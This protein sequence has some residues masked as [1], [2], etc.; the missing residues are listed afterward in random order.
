MASIKNLLFDMGAVL[1]NIDYNKTAR[2]FEELGVENFSKEFSQTTASP[3]FEE[4]EMGRISESAFYESIRK[5]FNITSDYNKIQNA[6]NAILEDFRKESMEFL[7]TL[8][9]NYR[10]F[11]LSNTNSIHLE[12]VNNILFN[13]LGVKQVDDYFEKAYYSHKV[14]MRK[15]NENIFQFVLEDA[16]IN[17]TETLFIDDTI[18]NIHTAN[19]LGF[20]THLLLPEERIEQLQYN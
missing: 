3:L 19:L 15:P 17:A 10:L 4:I 20:K 6:W 1:I 9:I 11:L 7:Q 5:E 14:G 12:E 16:E 18:S 13:Q 8:K 2:A